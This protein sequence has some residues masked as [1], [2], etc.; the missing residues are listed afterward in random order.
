M[1]KNITSLIESSLAGGKIATARLISKIEKGDVLSAAIMEAITPHSGDAYRIGV[2]GPPGAGKST[3][4]NRLVHLFCQNN[5]SV[6]VVAVDPSSPFSGGALLGDRV[7]MTANVFEHDVFFRSMSSNQTKGGLART[8]SE[9]IKILDASGRE[10]IIIE[11]VGVGQSEIDVAQLAD[12]I[13]VVLVPESG[14]KIQAIKAGLMEIADLFVVNKSDRAGA[15]QLS[16]SIQSTLQQ[17]SKKQEWIPPIFQTTAL[18]NFGIDEL[19]QGIWNHHQFLQHHLRLKL[20]RQKQ[21]KNELN[22]CLEKAFL[23]F[24]WSDFLEEKKLNELVHDLEENKIDVRSFA[25]KTVQDWL[26]KRRYI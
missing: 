26:T 6:G 20:R 11:T 25:E 7:R 18:K 15:E 22:Q 4:V 8:T 17:S 2:T 24:L 12:T 10:I 5:Y 19:Y 16:A 14:D 23:E 9:T 3:I 21:L 13:L 1:D